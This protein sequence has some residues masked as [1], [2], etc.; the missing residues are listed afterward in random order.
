MQTIKNAGWDFVAGEGRG[1]DNIRVENNYFDIYCN[2][3]GIVSEQQYNMYASPWNHPINNHHV[4]YIEIYNNNKGLVID[5]CIASMKAAQAAGSREVGI[6][7]GDWMAGVGVTSSTL[8][9]I[10]DRARN[11][12]VNCNNVMWW[13]GIGYDIAASI[14]G[15]CS[16]QVQGLVNH[17][18]IRHGIGGA[19]GSTPTRHLRVWL[20]IPG[21]MQFKE[22]LANMS[23]CSLVGHQ[24]Y[25]DAGG[26][27]IPNDKLTPEEKA[28]LD[29]KL[30]L[31]AECPSTANRYMIDVA[32]KYLDGA[33]SFA[34]TDNPAKNSTCR[35]Y[36]KG[37]MA[38]NAGVVSNPITIT[39]QVGGTVT[40]VTPD[41]SPEVTPAV[42]PGTVPAQPQDVTLTPVTPQPTAVPEGLTI[43]LRDHK[44]RA[45]T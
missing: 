19:G 33:F 27:W 20:S 34:F 37:Q 1:G 23:A 21:S 15:W 42:I 36:L 38:S 26:S 25:C 13:C 32:P 4:D 11:E 6:L 7:T 22:S 35:Y 17:Y 3:G 40:P 30:G 14:K 12:G 24:G 44:K 43:I 8:I 10:I 31:I 45:K 29:S 18:G 41:T 5:S 28:Y 9:G 2:Y 16:E 39:W